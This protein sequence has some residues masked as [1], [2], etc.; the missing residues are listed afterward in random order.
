MDK[1]SDE[2]F[3]QEFLDVSYRVLVN[4]LTFKFVSLSLMSSYSNVGHSE[5][6]SQGFVSKYLKGLSSSM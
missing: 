3:Q 4:L 6:N 2:L 5:V 1:I